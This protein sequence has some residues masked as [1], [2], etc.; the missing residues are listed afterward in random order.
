MEKVPKKRRL[1]VSNYAVNLDRNKPE[2]AVRTRTPPRRQAHH[3]RIILRCVDGVLYRL[4]IPL[5]KPSAC[6]V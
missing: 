2:A 4:I 1:G 5:V 6:V 3:A